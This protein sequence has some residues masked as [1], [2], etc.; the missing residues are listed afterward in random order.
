MEVDPNSISEL[1]E[2]I[3][4]EYQESP[5]SLAVTN[6]NIEIVHLLLRYGALPYFK[7]AEGQTIRYLTSWCSRSQSVNIGHAKVILYNT[8]C[9]QT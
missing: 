5:L 7:H 4:D 3:S 6:K 8:Q 1:G 9:R 2:T